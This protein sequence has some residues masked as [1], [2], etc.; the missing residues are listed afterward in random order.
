M[1]Y[2]KESHFEAKHSNE[3]EPWSYSERGAEILRHQWVSKLA[4]KLAPDQKKVLDVGCSFG[5]LSAS[6]VKAGL[7]LTAIDISQS[8]VE[9]ASELLRQIPLKS[10]QEPPR[11]MTG[12]AV[13]LQFEANSFDVVIFS[14]GLIG[15]ELSDQQKLQSLEQADRILKEGGYLILTDY[16]HPRNFAE[17]LK[18][19]KNGPLEIAQVHYLNDRLWFQLDANLKPLKKFAPV[20]SFLRSTSVAQV[21]ATLSSFLG[22]RGSKHLGV[23]MRKRKR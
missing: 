13:D 12:S 23:V 20:K 22:Y 18:L 9:K 14:D 2:E 8:A 16:L 7:N 17:H 11:S 15:W 10:G 1:A 21:L 19:I 3:L 5:Q 6:L 4:D